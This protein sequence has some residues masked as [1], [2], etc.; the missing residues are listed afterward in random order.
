MNKPKITFGKIQFG[1]KA[2]N[3]T[4]EEKDDQSTSGTNLSMF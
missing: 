1:K 2:T 4:S 3:D